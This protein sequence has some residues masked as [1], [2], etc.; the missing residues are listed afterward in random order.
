[1][2]EFTSTNGIIIA[3]CNSD[4]EEIILASTSSL[5]IP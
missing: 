5:Y 1:M 2:G 3:V 4:V